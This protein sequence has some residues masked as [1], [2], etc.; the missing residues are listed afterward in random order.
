MLKCLIYLNYNAFITLL[1]N[2][3]LFDL[4]NINDILQESNMNHFY[5]Y[6]L[7]V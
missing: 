1:E 5:I 2:I 4:F 7:G 3:L 6:S